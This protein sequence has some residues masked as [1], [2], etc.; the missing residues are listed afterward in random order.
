MFRTL[1]LREVMPPVLAVR[2]CDGAGNALLIAH[3]LPDAVARAVLLCHFVPS[4]T[5]RA[6]R[7]GTG[8]DFGLTL[9]SRGV[10][11][12][13]LAVGVCGNKGV[14]LPHARGLPDA[15]ARAVALCRFVPSMVSGA[16]RCGT[17]GDFGR[18][19][20]SRGVTP[21]VLAVG[22]CGSE[23]VALPHA[24][25]LPT[26]LSA[27]AAVTAAACRLAASYRACCLFSACA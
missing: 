3:G 15:A 23:G 13:V 14:A 16:T 17:R 5:G 8:G 26:T 10:T 21:P 7:C 2:M 24:R 12:P 19:L 9:V 22:V 18:T 20:M 4:M 11:P 25:G 1:V 6:T 27:T